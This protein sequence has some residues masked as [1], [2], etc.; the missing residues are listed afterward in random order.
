VIGSSADTF[1]LWIVATIHVTKQDH[2]PRPTNRTL[3]FGSFGFDIPVMWA[4]QDKL[5]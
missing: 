2:D 5:S 3:C 4:E 1:A